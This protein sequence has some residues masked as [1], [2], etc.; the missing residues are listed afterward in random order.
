MTRIKI[1][2]G[3]AYFSL[4]MSNKLTHNIAVCKKPFAN[5]LFTI[6]NVKTKF[7]TWHI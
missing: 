7:E 4:F 2:R 1:N 3:V 6:K 5:S